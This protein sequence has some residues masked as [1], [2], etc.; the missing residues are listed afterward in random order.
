MVRRIIG[1][2]GFCQ[3]SHDIVLVVS[4]VAIAVVV[5]DDAVVSGFEAA[6]VAVEV[7]AIVGNVAIAVVGG[8]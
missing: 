3:S 1:I 7:V 5:E 8:A 6:N 2:D 4:H